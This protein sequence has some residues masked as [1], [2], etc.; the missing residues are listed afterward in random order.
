MQY[1]HAAVILLK[2]HKPLPHLT[3]AFEAAKLRFHAE[4]D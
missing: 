3:S 4:V 2:I 1:Y